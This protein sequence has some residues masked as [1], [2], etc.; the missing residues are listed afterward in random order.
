MTAALAPVQ[1]I[2][3]SKYLEGATDVTL[4]KRMFMGWLDKAGRINRNATGK[5]LNWLIK[6]KNA[7]ASPYTPYQALSFS[8]DLYHTAMSLTPEYWHAESGMDIT[9]RLTNSGPTAIV[10]AYE[11]RYKEL[12]AAMEIYLAKSLYTDANVAAGANRVI[13]LGT[14][15]KK[16]TTIATTTADRLAAPIATASLYGGQS[17]A[18]GA[19]GGT[20]SSDMASGLRMN[21]ALAT[22]WPDGHGDASNAYDALSPRLYNE[23]S[24][25]WA[26]PTAA[27]AASSWRTNCVNMLSRANTD[28]R[29]NSMESM[30]PNIHLMGSSRYQ[31]V[32][33]KMRESFRDLLTHGPTENLGYHDSLAFEGALLDLD[34]ECP[35]SRTYSVCAGSM[36]LQFFGSPDGATATQGGV[37]DGSQMITG[38]IYT[39]FGPQRAPNSLQWTWIMFAG[40]QSRYSPK[41]VVCHSDFTD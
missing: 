16:S 35:A 1:T 9:E 4:R 12:E 24:N 36:D 13:G 21:T 40:G 14:I 41:W 38:G 25:Q 31:D 22:D 15:A 5:D 34:H 19:L 11:E 7:E 39:A 28:L 30:M 32:K 29:M 2:T 3:A 33:D 17:I 8:N 26:D 27:A 37:M 6:H 20:W 23:G 18:L 10:E